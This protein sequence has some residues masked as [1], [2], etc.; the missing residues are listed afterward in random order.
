MEEL[1]IKARVGYPTDEREIVR[2]LKRFLLRSALETPW[3]K[4]ARVSAKLIERYLSMRGIEFRTEYW[5]ASS[6]HDDEQT[7][8]GFSI[9]TALL[10]GQ[11]WIETEEYNSVPCLKIY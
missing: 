11:V 5:S 6:S 8:V 7:Y 1:K 3:Y 9:Q 10:G 2:N 4:D